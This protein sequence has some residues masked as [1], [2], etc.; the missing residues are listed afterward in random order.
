MVRKKEMDK[1]VNEYKADGRKIV[2]GDE[3]E[4]N[5]N[6]R[7]AVSFGGRPTLG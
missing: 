7:K 3:S 6:L 2:E 5:S 4:R 1:E